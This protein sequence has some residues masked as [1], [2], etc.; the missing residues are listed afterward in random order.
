MCLVWIFILKYAGLS[1]ISDTKSAFG[2]NRN[3]SHIRDQNLR[4]KSFDAIV[5]IYIVAS[6]IKLKCVYIVATYLH[7]MA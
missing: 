4:L 5:K 6:L 1:T 3:L 7:L 2:F